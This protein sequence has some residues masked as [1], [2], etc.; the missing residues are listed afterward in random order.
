M[1]G[2][3]IDVT[4]LRVSAPFR[5]VFGAQLVSNI[6]SQ[7]TLVALMLQVYDLTGSP[8]KVGL[9][10]LAMVVPTV[11]LALL[12][13]AI[14]DSMDRARL[15]Q[16]VQVGMMV[17][18]ATLAILS[19]HG[20]P[21]IWS[22]YALAALSS[23]FAA[24]DGPTRAAVL[25][26]LVDSDT[27]RSAVQLREVLTQAGR[28]LGPVIGGLLV[29]GPGYAW[30]YGVDASSFAIALV[31]FLGLPKLEPERRTRVSLESILDS[32]RFVRQRPVLAST[33]VA[34]LFA[35]VLGM[36]RALFPAMAV[37]VYGVGKAQ[38]GYLYAAPAAGALFGLVLLGGLTSRVRRE[39]LAVLVAVSIWGI[40]IAAFAIAPWFWAGLVLLAI[41]G[42]ADMVSAIFRQTILLDIVPDE[43][44][45]RLG[46]VHIMVVTGGPPIGDLE[47][48]LAA[49]V[50][51]VRPSAVVGGL[52]CVAGMVLIARRVPEFARWLP[53]RHHERGAGAGLDELEST[54]G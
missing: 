48:G 2:L 13:G 30:A 1:A 28:T 45:G 26:M 5:R 39:G 42:A 49:E 11:V 27:L 46:A 18:S 52:G 17:P 34:D 50:L 51:G 29:A 31:L 12:G 7:V 44:R 36:P 3:A 37:I 53:A 6:G 8:G 21:P 16:L 32:V 33:F 43:M 47:A 40:A 38:A 9:L 22:L 20:S 35:M 14:A 24:L 25:P 41:A 19:A 54:S 23:G 4:A 15:L 10:G